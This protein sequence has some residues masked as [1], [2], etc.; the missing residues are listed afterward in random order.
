MD[1]VHNSTRMLHQLRS[2]TSLQTAQNNL[3]SDQ[4]YMA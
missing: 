3:Y 2:V 4:N 1:S